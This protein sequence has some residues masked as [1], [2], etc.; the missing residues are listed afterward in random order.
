MKILIANIGNRDMKIRGKEKISERLAAQEVLDFADDPE[1][2]REYSAEISFP[3][4]EPLLEECGTPIDYL[5]AFVT[6]QHPSA[7]AMYEKDTILTGHA[8]KTLFEK[9]IGRFAEKIKHV[10]L[11]VVD[12]SPVDLD[13]LM[14]LYPTK[15]EKLGEADDL[16]ENQSSNEIF[17]SITGGT[18]ACNIALLYSTINSL[19]IPGFKNYL[20]VTEG[21]DR[22]QRLQAQTMIG[23]VEMIKF[24]ERLL[25]QWD[26]NGISKLLDSAFVQNKHLSNMVEALELRVNF[27]FSRIDTPLQRSLNYIEGS[28]REIFQDLFDETKAVNEA[29]DSFS[30]D[31][32]KHPEVP[33]NELFWNMAMKYEVGDYIDFIGRFYRFS[34]AL[35]QLELCRINNCSLEQLKKVQGLNCIGENLSRSEMHHYLVRPKIGAEENLVK[36][37][38]K[39][40]TS[41]IIHLRNET[42]IAHDMRGLSKKQIAKI[43][44]GD[45]IADTKEMLEKYLGVVLVNPYDRYNSWLVRYI[46]EVL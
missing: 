15:L 28:H 5:L 1:L 23:R 39:V 3:L 13:S 42:I 16:T 24:I 31:T 27:H 10:E 34:E 35:M 25:Q 4:L 33:L 14:K 37:L 32:P 36:W 6:D 9:N 17:I 26:Y 45:I 46:H 21:T 12:E 18:P 38:K 11:V 22:A 41:K 2:L 8:I 19:A 30:S 43:W 20:Y 29:I 40:Y 44:Q 7:G